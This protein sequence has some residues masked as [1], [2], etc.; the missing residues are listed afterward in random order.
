MC[1]VQLLFV[2][3]RHV[4]PSGEGKF[5][6][7]ARRVAQPLAPPP[8]VQ[9]GPA[10]E[11]SRQAGYKCGAGQSTVQWQS[12]APTTTTETNTAA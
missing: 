10:L 9:D 5:D 1:I 12:N 8:A 3:T 11:Q 2:D 7:I 4:V 6:A